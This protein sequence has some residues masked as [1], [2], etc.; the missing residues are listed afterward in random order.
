V[1]DMENEGNGWEKYK[2]H[3]VHELERSNE[4]L[5]TIDRRLS[6]IE[7]RL[8]VLDTKVYAATFV[9]SGIC[10]AVFNIIAGKF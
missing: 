10:T 6:K 4:R 9:F 8:A 1:D 5:G 7:N 2:L 3:V